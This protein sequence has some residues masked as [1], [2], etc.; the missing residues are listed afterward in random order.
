MEKVLNL[1]QTSIAEKG[2]QVKLDIPE[3][4]APVMAE[5]DGLVQILLNLLDNAVK[6]TPPGGKIDIGSWED[7]EYVYIAIQ[8]TGIGIPEEGLPRIFERFY[9]V[10]R[11]RSSEIPG[12]GLGLSVVKHLVQTFEGEV[13]V[14][15][16]IGQGTRF[17]LKLPQ[18]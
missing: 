8:D 6:Y 3:N 13:S 2:H 12:T 5:E 17:T 11:A 18:A 7:A 10:D 1:L 4:I 14:S 16:K 9:R 15:S